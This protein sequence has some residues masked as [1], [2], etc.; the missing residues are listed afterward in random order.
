MKKLICTM[1]ACLLA[2]SVLA[3]STGA[4]AEAAVPDDAAFGGAQRLETGEIY[5]IDLDGD[6]W[7]EKLR[8]RFDEASLEESLVLQ[9]ETA[10]LIYEYPTYIGWAEETFC[11]DLDGDGR[12][13]ILLCG[14]E[15]S[16][17]FVTYCLNFDP[18]E[19][20]QAL[21]FADAGRGENTGEYAESGYG[22]LDAIDGSKLTLTG[23]Q[24]ALGTWWC[25]REFT[26][27]DGRFE[28]DDDGIWH[29][30]EDFDDPE[31]WEYRALTPT[32]ELSV[33]LDDGSAA[34]L[35]V[36][37][38]LLITETDKQSYVGFV[39]EK[40]V[41]GRLAIAPD[42]ENGWGF[43]VDGVPEADCFEYVPYA[44]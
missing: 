33:T 6:G 18:D 37:D 23:S 40:G 12:L 25:A 21:Q 31:L 27:R 5:Q 7:E 3:V 30:V 39:T 2:L 17:D 34:T 9:V 1:S 32:R 20:L 41:R 10:Q 26:L 38:R 14:D 13:E 16:S 4:F 28:L 36:G 35:D 11:A 8:V 42:T 29:V 15:A 19:G 44:D 43:M 24:D 22:R